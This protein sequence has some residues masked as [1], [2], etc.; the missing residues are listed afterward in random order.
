MN[1]LELSKQKI[2]DLFGTPD[3]AALPDDP[4]FLEIFK[5]F[6]FGEVYSQ[7]SLDDKT[8][9]LITLVVLA[10]NQTLTQIR[11]HVAAGLNIGLTPVEMK[12]AVYQCAP[13]IGFPKAI[14]ALNEV[15]AAFKERNI[16]L[17][18]E[19]QSRTIEGE[20]FNKGLKTQVSIF[21][22]TINQMHRSAPENQKHIQ[23]YLSAFCFGDFYTRDGLDLRIREL[24]TLCMVSSL[25]GCESQVKGHVQGNLNVGNGKETMIAA[26]TQCLPYMGFPRT[27]NALS[28]INEVIPEKKE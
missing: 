11:G 27:L 16:A 13:Y 7:G 4:E 24:L 3:L 23:A 6:V 22:D 17:P 19:S 18:L 2:Y 26:I 28:C 14:N 12:E 21:G 25:G 9:V 1:R 20:R 15:N 10:V 8:R 5:R